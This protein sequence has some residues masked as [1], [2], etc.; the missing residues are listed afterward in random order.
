MSENSTTAKD[1]GGKPSGPQDLRRE[2]WR[3]IAVRTTREFGFDDLPDAAAALTYYGVLT[4]FPALIAVVAGFVV[5]GDGHSAIAAVLS[6]VED[7]FPGANT[8]AVRSALDDLA[9]T[10]GWGAFVFG[11]AFAVWTMSR[12]VGAFSRSMNRIYEIDEGRGFSILKPQQ[13][14]ISVVFLVLAG[15]MGAMVIVSGPIAT[16]VAEAFGIGEPWT[17]IWSVAKWPVIVLLAVL[18]IGL[19]YYSTPNVHQRRFRWLS[20]GALLALTVLIVSSALFFLYIAGFSNY[21]RIY[22]SLA[23]A[24]IFLIWVWIANLALLFGAEFDSEVERGRQLQAGIAAEESLQLDPR[25]TRLAEKRAAR[26]QK[27]IADGRDIRYNSAPRA[28]GGSGG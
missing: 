28:P 25:D 17:G 21:D 26:A 16:S 23:G 14:L 15:V 12:Y 4:I 24:L 2:T 7:A 10:S 13:L 18:L 9:R 27:Q 19:L 22:G 20:M 6:I 1:D 3:Y 8:D 11:I 5:F